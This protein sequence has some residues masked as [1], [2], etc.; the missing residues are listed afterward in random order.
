MSEIE[1]AL[2]QFKPEADEV[3]FEDFN[4]DSRLKDRVRQGLNLGGAGAAPNGGVRRPLSGGIRLP[5]LGGVRLPL[6]GS[7]RRA[8]KTWLFGTVAA[9]VVT[10]VL[11]MATPALRQPAV[12]GSK[13]DFVGPKVS[14]T[15]FGTKPTRN[16]SEGKSAKTGSGWKSAQSPA[17]PNPTEG[18]VETRIPDNFI[19]ST[20]ADGHNGLKMALPNQPAPPVAEDAQKR[21]GMAKELNGNDGLNDRL[22]PAPDAVPARITYRLETALPAAPVQARSF[23][24]D[25][26]KL[27]EAD[28]KALALR[29][30]F[31][32]PQLKRVNGTSWVVG[33]DGSGRSITD[34]WPANKGQP[35]TWLN[36]F[37]ARHLFWDTRPGPAPPKTAPTVAWLEG[38]AR[39]WLDKYGLDAGEAVEWKGELNPRSL[40]PDRYPMLL[41]TPTLDGFPVN[42]TGAQFS[43]AGDGTVVHASFPLWRV[44]ALPAAPLKTPDE[45]LEE[46]KARSIRLD[47]KVEHTVTITKA[48]LVYGDPG[49]YWQGDAE[50]FYH[51]QGKD[52][53]GADFDQYVYARKDRT[54]RAP[55]ERP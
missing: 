30:G 10:A 11:I 55:W 7:V 20:A 2:H 16:E 14:G 36:V 39:A 4:F 8:W 15:S 1:K 31:A 41:W 12:L 24:V 9:A 37:E 44:E 3:L 17:G 33:Q 48:E 51:F 43:V 35:G 5:F 47:K 27:T 13:E 38:A 32:D 18:S 52:D 21:D 29:F 28:A 53:N 49:A 19:G 34:A 25:R 40:E 54:G 42:T 45:A 6:L 50:L 26:S 46:L 23:K 22:Y